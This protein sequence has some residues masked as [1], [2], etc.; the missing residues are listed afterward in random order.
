MSIWLDLIFILFLVVANGFFACSE[1][2]II[3]A[4]KSKIAQLIS[5][6]NEKAE[7]VERLQ[8]DPHRFL[9]TVQVGMTLVGSTASAVG[10]AVAVQFLKP[11][12]THAPFEFVRNAAS[13]LALTFA[14]ILV[15]YLLLVLGELVPKT[16]GLHYADSISLLVAKP[17]HF[18]SL[19]GVVAIGLLTFSSKA[20]LTLLR[21]KGG[22]GKAFITKDEVRHIVAEGEKSGVF[23]PI[24]HEFIQN[25]FDFTQT[26][27]REVM[28]PRTRVAGVDL[29]LS[30]DEIVKQV[31][32]HK[33]SR[34]PVFKGS[35]EN[36][37]GFIHGKDLLGKMVTEPDFDIN[38]IVRPPFYVPEMKKVNDL[39]KEMQK[40]RIH[41]AMVV[42]EYGGI[43]GLVTTED[44]LE[45]LVGEIEDEHDVG[46][47][48][49]IQRLADGSFSVDALITISDLEDMLETKLGEDLP[50]DTLAGLILEKLGRFPERGEKLEL[51]GYMLICEEVKKTSIVKVRIVSVAKP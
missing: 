45:E 26:C 27:V 44:L 49:R 31:L 42:D 38:D 10:G 41:M 30:K 9:A 23:S 6:G 13:P 17:I 36:I 4:R 43:S 32:E 20:I 3:S 8:N 2:A 25:I 29:E 24:E 28:V 51:D 14:V 50:Y 48:R 40:K 39:L 21:V 15:S 33:Y 18:F 35:I 1:L 47:P 12:L 37:A 22:T 11:A 19:A 5:K 7:V 46:E 16:F 34:Y